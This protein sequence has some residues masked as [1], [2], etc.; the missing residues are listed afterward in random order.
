MQEENQNSRAYVCLLSSLVT[1]PHLSNYAQVV[2]STTRMQPTS[3]FGFPY[4]G[5]KK[6]ACKKCNLI[7]LVLLDQLLR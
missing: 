3:F 7:N 6:Y 2:N 1:V 5:K 4:T